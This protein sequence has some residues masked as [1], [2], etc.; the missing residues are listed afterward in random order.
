MDIG[1]G[2][3][4]F[5]YGPAYTFACLRAFLPS[6]IG[7]DHNPWTSVNGWREVEIEIPNKAQFELLMDATGETAKN[8]VIG[9]AQ[10]STNTKRSGGNVTGARVSGVLSSVGKYF[11][12]AVQA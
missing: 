2:Y 9:N 8:P 4:D 10:F 3:P 6:E 7:E 5:N 11:E 1:E 12:C